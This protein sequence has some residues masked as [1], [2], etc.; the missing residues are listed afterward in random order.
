[1]SNWHRP[2]AAYDPRDETSPPRYGGAM[3][4]ARYRIAS[5]LTVLLL[6]AACDKPKPT[7]LVLAE[8]GPTVE[9]EAAAPVVD[10]SQC[11]GCQLAPI[12]AWTFEGIYKDATCTEPLAQLVAPACTVVPA[13]GAAVSITYVDEAP[14][15]KVNETATV[16]LVDQV[17]AEA[18]HYRKTTKGCVR[19]NEGA[20]DITPSGCANAKACR[21]Q[22]GALTCTTCR[23]FANGCP[24]YEETRLYAT[25]KD[26]K[27]PAAA[28]GGNLARLAQ[29]CNALAAQ[30][31][32]ML[33]AV[34]VS[35]ADL[36]AVQ[37]DRAASWAERHRTRAG[38]GAFGARGAQ[39]PRHLRGILIGVQLSPR[40]R[41]RSRRIC[42]APFPSGWR[43]R[44][45]SRIC[46]EA[47]LFASRWPCTTLTSDASAPGP[48]DPAR[49]SAASSVMSPPSSARAS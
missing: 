28:G 14:P 15:R 2:A 35:R 48:T 44:T 33:A 40:S 13:L 37:R 43:A 30:A 26:D 38:R 6:V 7:G 41:R 24:D 16:T 11:A 23:T 39:R 3:L 17:A 32:A 49:R 12:P 29:C 36:H 18:P 34:R 5:A 19:A 4:T 42:P 47:S 10:L 22:N 45:A 25:I 1:M 31:K 9:A 8:A 27:K 46:S 21:D 20:V